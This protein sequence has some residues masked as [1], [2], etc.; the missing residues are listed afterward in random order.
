MPFV[1]SNRENLCTLTKPCVA[2]PL[3][4]KF[5]FTKYSR[6][7]KW[8]FPG[9][10]VGLQ[11]SFYLN[12]QIG[13]AELNPKCN[14]YKSSLNNK[15]ISNLIPKLNF[16]IDNSPSDWHGVFS[17][18]LQLLVF[19]VPNAGYFDDRSSCWLVIQLSCLLFS[20]V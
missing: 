1:Y 8:G 7:R 3:L 17:V 12:I 20:S 15:V 19:S 2:F 18:W 4:Y 5:Q 11:F 9:D 10:R 14:E 16:Q 6:W 13:L